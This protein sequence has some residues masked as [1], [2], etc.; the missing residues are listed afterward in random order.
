MSHRDRAT[1]ETYFVGASRRQERWL[2]P[3]GYSEQNAKFNIDRHYDWC[4]TCQWKIFRFDPHRSCPRC[5]LSRPREFCI[6]K[7]SITARQ[8]G[9]Q[10]CRRMTLNEI[11]A[12][13]AIEILDEIECAWSIDNE[14]RINAGGYLPLEQF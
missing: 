8:A 5:R 14:G 4:P 6:G 1:S 7:R 11:T 13:I 9:C 10:H 3:N 2:F 12:L